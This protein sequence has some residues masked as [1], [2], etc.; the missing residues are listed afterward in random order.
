MLA[1]F[2]LLTTLIG[3]TILATVAT[4][5]TT[6]GHSNAFAFGTLTLLEE[7]ALARDA[8]VPVAGMMVGQ[9]A[10]DRAPLEPLAMPL[11]GRTYTIT[12][13]DAAGLV[14]LNTAAPE[15]LTALFEDIGAD[16]A[17][18]LALRE[19][20]ETLDTVSDLFG[21]RPRHAGT[22]SRH[23]RSSHRPFRAQGP[24][25]GAHPTGPARNPR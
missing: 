2:S 4:L 8:A 10:I 5:A 12:V 20:R 7:R 11:N 1:G 21:P 23:A 18:L 15:M 25:P 16:P 19:R 17:P 6:T 22:V 13:R 24:R 3:L 14:D 9:A